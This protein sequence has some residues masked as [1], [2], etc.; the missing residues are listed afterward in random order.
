MCNRGGTIGHRMIYLHPEKNSLCF[1]LDF[2]N[3]RAILICAA[4]SLQSTKNS[5]AKP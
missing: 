3:Q 5:G 2:P 1:R 4:N